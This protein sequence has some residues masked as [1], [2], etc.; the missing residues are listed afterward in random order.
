[1]SRRVLFAVLLGAACHRP[2]GTAPYQFESQPR[3][4]LTETGAASSRH[5]QLAV[6]SSGSIYLLALEGEDEQ[7]GLALWQSSDGGD[8]FGPPVPLPESRARVSSHGENSPHLAVTPT[9]IYALWEQPTE[10]GPT[11]VVLSRSLDFGRSFEKPGL[12]AYNREPSFNGFASLAARSDGTVY[13]VWLDGR[14]APEVPGTFSLYLAR[15]SDRGRSFGE[16]VRIAG[17]A[18]PCCR[19]AVGFGMDG[20]VVVAS[21]KVFDQDVR[22]MVAS[23]SRDGGRSFE[24]PIRVAH[25]N[26]RINGC[27]DSGPAL[28]RAGNRLF[29]AWYTE[30]GGA[31]PGVRLT[32][33][34][35]GGNSFRPPI[36]VSADV[37][38]ANHPALA[39]GQDNGVLVVFQGR[40]PESREGWS[41]QQTYFVEIGASGAASSPVALSSRSGPASYPILARGSA[42]RVFLA[43]T[44]PHPGGV[45]QVV[46]S[47]GRRRAP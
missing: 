43:W 11:R 5:P 22:D 10:T 18:C 17:R 38:D 4:V 20:E 45:T 7:S 15:S 30:P 26:W 42:A 12:V 27:P 29:V 39:V 8:T 14:D 36:L 44:E 2:E 40:D 6:T 16:N 13:A 37:L 9:E 24:D 23:F 3:A 28:A 46:L 47:R 31:K 19:P 33:S 25:D 21:R 34:D 32:W 1:M 41:A 35:E